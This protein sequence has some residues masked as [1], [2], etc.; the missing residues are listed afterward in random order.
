MDTDCKVHC[1][2]QGAENHYGDCGSRPDIH[3]ILIPGRRGRLLSVLYTAA[4]EGAHPT[5]LLLHGI[6]GCERNFDLAQALRRAGFHVM[7]FHYSGNWGSDGDYSLAHDLEDANTVLDYLLADETYGVDKNRIY[8]VGHSLG[9]FVCGQ[10]T[11]RRK[12]IQGGV[13]LMPC[14]IGRLP[15]I[16]AEDERAYRI[17]LEVLEDSAQWLNGVT[18][19][20]LW[21]EAET[22]AKTFRLESTAAQL[23]KK[24]LMC[25]GGDLDIYTPPAYHCEPLE[26]A[27]RAEG[28]TLLRSVRYPTDHFFA[29]F[30]LTAAE[31]ITEFL[32][33]L[34]AI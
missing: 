10:L 1:T 16:A 3:G 7:T 6:P 20:G 19:E 14:D 27:I 25:V 30:R 17:I 23:A 12:E 2:A 26:R 5:V 24:P 34:L 11:A 9:G 18:G 28:G 15:Q 31:A 33:G 32:T 4:G 29:D 13:L 22:H 21:R 8:A